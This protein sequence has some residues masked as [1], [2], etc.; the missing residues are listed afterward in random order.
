MRQHRITIEDQRLADKIHDEHE[1]WLKT[2]EPVHHHLLHNLRRVEIDYPAA[3]GMLLADDFE[4]ADETAIQ[5][6][7]DERVVFH[8]CDHGRVHTNLTNLKSTLRPFLSYQGQPLVNLD[9]GNSQPL[10]FSILLKDRYSQAGTMP[11]DVERY[12][13]LVQGGKFY[14]G[15][16]SEAGI[17]EAKRSE[18]KRKF[19]GHV[20]FCENW[21]E[22]EAARSSAQFPQVCASFGSKG[23]YTALAKD[24]QRSRIRPDDR[25]GCRPG[26]ARVPHAFIGTIHDSILTT[27]DQA[28]PMLA[29]MPRS[30]AGSACDR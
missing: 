5:M 25:Q 21:P 20:F 16:M 12:V 13:G 19:F 3:L 11:A 9:I 30:S 17:P 14:D 10:F 6:L 18:F 8:V 1:D 2:P 27:P 4:P 23:G 7:R 28:E 29:I 24:L 15:L 22:T 26:H